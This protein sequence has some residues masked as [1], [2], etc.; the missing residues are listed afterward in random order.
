MRSTSGPVSLAYEPQR[1]IKRGHVLA[2]ETAAR[3]LGSLAASEALSLVLLYEHEGD[4]RSERAFQR[5]LRRVRVEHALAHEEVELLRSAAGALGSRFHEVALS[6][7]IETCRELA[8]SPPTL[9]S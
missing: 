5:W 7:L 4:P 3:E 2:A 1:A 8:L 9:P 6:V